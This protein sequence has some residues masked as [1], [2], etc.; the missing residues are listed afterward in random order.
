MIEINVTGVTPSGTTVR[1]HEDEDGYITHGSWNGTGVVEVG[2][3]FLNIAVPSA[4]VA[5][6][7]QDLGSTDD[8]AAAARNFRAV[9]IEIAQSKTGIPAAFIRQVKA[10]IG[11]AYRDGVR[12]GADAARSEIRKALRL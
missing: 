7:I 6:L 5:G 4:A 9:V 3:G 8:V 2:D 11:N 1:I 10:V 12:H